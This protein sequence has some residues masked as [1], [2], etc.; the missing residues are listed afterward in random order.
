MILFFPLYIDPGTGSMLFSILIGAT[1]TLYFLGRAAALKLK[2]LFTGKNAKT[3]TATHA[4]VIYNE[5]KQYWT[6]FC[7]ILDEFE[8][9]EIP[10]AYLT[11]AKD[12]EAFSRE[13]KYVKPEFIGEGNTAFARLNML[14]ADVL[15]ATTPGLD[16]YQ[17]KRSK[18]VKHYSHLVHGIG[19]VTTYRMF[20][21]DYFDSVLLGGDYQRD[22]IRALEKL[23]DLPQKELVTVGSTYMDVLAEKI[24]LVP[25]ESNHQFTVLLSP[26]WGPSGILSKY[27][28]RLLDPLV[29]SGWRIIVRPH[30]QSKKSESDMLAMLEERYKDNVNVEWNYDR[31]N[32][33]ALK[34]SDVMI[35]D[36]SGIIFD[37]AFLC[38]KPVFYAN[39]DMNLNIYDAAWLDG[40]PWHLEAVKRFGIPLR[41]NDFGNIVEIIGKANEDTAISSERE[42]VKRE[43]WMY[44]GEAAKRTVDFM[45]QKRE[46]I[47]SDGQLK[48][49]GEDSDS[50]NLNSDAISIASSVL[51]CDVSDIKNI[52]TLEKGMTNHSF[53]FEV[54][55]EKYIM[56]IPGEGTE[57]LINRYQEAEVYETI[58]NH[59]LC[60]DVLYINPKNGYKITKF[61]KDARVCDAH[62]A[63][64]LK[65]CMKK[66]RYL[67]ELKL[68]VNHE[69]N[70][71]KQINYYESLWGDRKSCFP[72]YENTKKNVF[73]LEKFIESTNPQK[74]LSHIDAVSDNF[75]FSEVNGREV[76]QLIDWEYA[77]MQDPI[78]DIAMFCIYALYETKS[79]IDRVIDFY[80][81]EGCSAKDRAKIYCYISICGLLWSNW[82]EYKKNLGIEFGEYSLRQYRFAK[83]YFKIAKDEIEK[84]G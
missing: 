4:Y 31:D 9:R 60:S 61:I 20:G 56:R 18:R 11:S 43:A 74:V 23:R 81:T 50:G 17:W 10:V 21:L 48:T 65:K 24:K 70:L 53:L 30:P 62:N 26:S 76:V 46:K 78:V 2:F 38:G 42:K 68:Q 7:Q 54:S 59:N 27:G 19:D 63:D 1:A 72:D 16:V 73:S 33:Y 47:N 39:A 64:D 6:M 28:E 22:A 35:S 5:G 36:F 66:I 75:L 44:Q 58:K 83:D 14:S 13:W 69:F 79:E 71:F 12:D 57:N 3:D 45:I 77:A 34:K 80:F 67:H 40:K 25:A 41:E 49:G 82:C 32:I 15:L 52:R 37:Y 55:N 8:R 84:L 51:G 29:A